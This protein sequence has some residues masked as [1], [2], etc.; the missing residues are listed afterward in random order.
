VPGG[1]AAAEHLMS[2]RRVFS[3]LGPNLVVVPVGDHG[4]RPKIQRVCWVVAL[5]VLAS[6]LATVVHSVAAPGGL[7]HQAT[8][9]AVAPAAL[10]VRTSTQA[11]PA[12][13]AGFVG[14]DVL[15]FGDAPTLGSLSNQPLVAP[16]LG[17]AATPDGRGYWLVASDGG[18]FSFGEAVFYG[19]TGGLRLN[20]PV[21]GMA[22]TPDGRGYWLVASDGGIFSFGDAVFRGS[23][24]GGPLAQPVV[25]MLPTVDDG[26]YWLFEGRRLA[27]RVAVID[28]GHNGGNAAHP[29]II[30]QL[31][32][33]ITGTKECDTTG[34]TTD[35]GYPE[36]AY[37]FDVAGRA[38]ALLLATGA[39]VILTRSDNNGVGP[40]IDIR[41]AIGNDAHAD[42]AV[43]IHAD[44]GPPSGRG[45]HVIEPAL[46][47]G[48]NDAIVGPSDQF[49]LVLRD[50]YRAATSLPFADYIGS[51]GL[52]TR[53]DL[54]G[55]N[56]ST[57]PKAF[58]ETGNMRNAT[59]APLLEDPGFRQQAAEG[60]AQA[61]MDFLSMR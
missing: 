25:G 53:N 37:N 31:V 60:I 9:A 48:H 41:A 7:G 40:C 4:A 32:D 52:D 57:V 33:I 59:D 47:P 11:A 46:L 10:V 51:E 42:V 30:N 26:G 43:S 14:G 3:R 13:A 35:S 12:A 6:G 44:G 34:T 18:I 61:V 58:I 24:A 56:L 8:R 45:F 5:G 16:V 27:G 55:L 2:R 36:A 17:M 15:D 22:A 1:A 19:S 21:V 50:D 23:G 39:T 49:A 20:R 28:P 38:E 54:G 29:E